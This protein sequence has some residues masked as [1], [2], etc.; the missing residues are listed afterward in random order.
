MSLG[1][2]GGL[3]DQDKIADRQ[4]AVVAA[5]MRSADQRGSPGCVVRSTLARRATRTAGAAARSH[6]LFAF[7]GL[8]ARTRDDD[9]VEQRS[10]TS[11]TTKAN[12]LVRP[13]HDRMPI[14]LAPDAY[15]AWLDPALDG[16]AARALLAHDDPERDWAREPVSTWVN[17]AD[18]DDATCI[19]PA[20]TDAPSPQRQLFE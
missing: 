11:I 7:A 5:L 4:N 20:A 15:D 18:H 10:F 16:D 19:A 14:V 1:N 12:D 6:H 2:V 17:K 9:G 13:I 8:W 3:R